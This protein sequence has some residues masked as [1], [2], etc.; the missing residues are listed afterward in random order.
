MANFR[1]LVQTLAAAFAVALSACGNA[2][3][4]GLA[5]DVRRELDLG[6][7]TLDGWI[8]QQQAG[9]PPD[10]IVIALGYAERLRLGLGN[11]FRLVD[12]A[13]QDPRLDEPVRRRL[14]WGL[15][16]RTL[17]GDAYEIDPVALDRGGMAGVASWP[18][19]G[20]HHLK[21]IESTIIAASDPR[22]GELAV[23]LA[24]RL[25]AMEGSVPSHAPAVATRAAALL[26]DREIAR[27]DV[28]RLLRSARAV[29]A[30]ALAA[31]ATW[32]ERRWLAVEAPPLAALPQDAEREALELAPRLAQS[33]RA[34]APRL[35]GVTEQRESMPDVNVSWLTA[36]TAARLSAL[37]DS[38]NA[39]PQAPVAIAARTYRSELMHQPWLTAAERK[40]R[41]WF[42]TLAS[43]EKLAAGYAQLVRRSP[44]DAAPSLSMVWAAVALRSY[45]QERVWFPG[46]GGPSTRDLQERFGLAD[47]RFTDRVPEE[48]RPFYRSMLA[49]SLQDMQDVLPSLNVKGLSVRFG[50]TS[51]SSATLAMHDPRNRRLLLPPAS[52]AG[53]IAHE[54]AH[55]LDWQVALSRYR[56]RGDYGTD[57]AER[58]GRDR[59]AAHVRTLVAAA[60]LD[61]PIGEA[62]PHARRPA[63]NFARAI[64]WLVA[65]S[66]AADGR[67]NG[68]LTSIQDDVLTGY[69]TVRAPDI[70]GRAGDAIV[71]ILDVV[72]PLY[73]D[74]RTWYLRT[75]GTTRALGPFDLM[76]TM[77]Q[78]D[79]P[80][81]PAPY[82][83]ADNDAVIAAFDALAS[84]RTYGMQ[85]VD[86]WMCR[87]PAGAH[88][89]DLERARRR[90]VGEAAGARA[91][92][93]ALQHARRI[94]GDVGVRWMYRQL[95]GGPFP[96]QDLEPGVAAMLG[97]LA[98]AARNIGVE[99]EVAPELSARGFELMW[100][101]ATCNN[102]E[103]FERSELTL[104]GRSH[105]R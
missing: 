75:Y 22:G 8:H 26:R 70:T 17:A 74:T 37:A 1:R 2:E 16:A 65:A 94:S 78:I 77:Q 42:T 38:L 56:V 12:Y 4:A 55:D 60:T 24:Y 72:A 13:L 90:F 99:D 103:A 85:A 10:D 101:P 88:D 28:R 87:A 6:A 23:R 71:D 67:S 58:L 62:E 82:A 51:K 41:T 102:V 53:T 96:L 29:N 79:L 89:E 61:E 21:L 39:P 93:V 45:A 86:E 104:R 44:Y 19:L 9:L 33:L 52:A 66:L 59:L 25:A 98:D 49:S 63:E 3:H 100:R 40:R 5:S 11:P 95:Y 81:M 83:A 105:P 84:A 15:L 20:R 91:R 7:A 73:D 54:V 69:G 47:V 46:F 92:G 18:G 35:R 36:E 57:R 80:S 43:E 68:Y 76:R 64:D 14:A 31:I 32:R 97:E 27:S 30:D 48:W 34:L 50:A